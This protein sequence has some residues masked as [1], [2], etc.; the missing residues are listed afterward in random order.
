MEEEDMAQS[1]SW[2]YRRLCIKQQQS[3]LLQLTSPL[4]RISRP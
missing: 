1:Q 3:E 4:I 2:E